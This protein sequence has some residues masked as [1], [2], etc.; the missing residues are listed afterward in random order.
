MP[1]LG[2]KPRTRNVKTLALALAMSLL[3]CHGV[4]GSLHFF[5]APTG[6]Q[7]VFGAFATPGAPHDVKG[8]SEARHAGSDDSGNRDSAASNHGGITDG[9]FAV[10]F[11][12]LLG[13]ILWLLRSKNVTPIRHAFTPK[14]EFLSRQI[15][16]HPPRG[17]TLSALQV[18]RL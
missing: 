3:A 15:I 2:R 14:S 18:F 4:S 13:S 6:S 7:P 12:A 17:P 1:S 16:P 11:A 9:C 10:L 5:H 8:H